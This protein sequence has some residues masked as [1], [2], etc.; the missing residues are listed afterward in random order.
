MAHDAEKVKRTAAEWLATN[1]VARIS[2]FAQSLGF[3]D[4]TARADLQR[5]AS[6]EAHADLA[7]MME[8]I[9]EVN[10]NISVL[11]AALHASTFGRTFWSM[12]LETKALA[13]VTYV[14]A[15]STDTAR[16]IRA[17]ECYAWASFAAAACAV[18][19]RSI[20]IDSQLLREACPPGAAGWWW[21]ETPLQP[22]SKPDLK[23][24]VLSWEWSLPEGAQR[25][26]LMCR[27]WSSTATS[28][29]RVFVATCASWGWREGESPDQ[30]AEHRRSTPVMVLDI[31]DPAKPFD[32]LPQRPETEQERDDVVAMCAYL[33][34]F[35]LAGCA[36]L[37]Q[38]VVT[39]AVGHIERHRRK[40]LAREH[41]LP[42]SV[43]VIQLRRSERHTSERTGEP[44]EATR[45]YM[46]RWVVDGHWRNQACGVRF[47]Q[48]KL[49]YVLPYVKGPDDRPLM[50]DKRDRVFAVNR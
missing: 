33:S 23:I 31:T 43:K 15:S 48:R 6:G 21:F 3:D 27:A 22:P 13:L 4:A 1:N 19:S 11:R 17:A 40:Q 41:G 8:Q 47:S 34:R 30:A 14:S 50:T 12:A 49:I 37:T 16:H 10:R 7:A 44:D 29:N 26:E 32:E 36:W 46:C 28:N 35:F 39:E 20:P 9:D 5:I 25:P 38:R 42:P 45:Q 24:D 18:A 2:A